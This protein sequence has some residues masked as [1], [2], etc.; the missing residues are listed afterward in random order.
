MYALKNLKIFLYLFFY[1]YKKWRQVTIAQWPAIASFTQCRA[2]L[3]PIWSCC[4]GRSC[5]WVLYTRQHNDKI[6]Y[7]SLILGCNW[8]VAIVHGI[9]IFGDGILLL[10]WTTTGQSDML[11]AAEYST[12]I[13]FICKSLRCRIV[14]LVYQIFACTNFIS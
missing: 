12:N 5:C 3:I 10:T 2:K 4:G 9:I 13:D 8:S 11:I 1:S 14:V 7:F 6:C